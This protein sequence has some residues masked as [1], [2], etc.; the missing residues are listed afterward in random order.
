MSQAGHI[1]C[2]MKERAKP[3]DE[4]VL[5]LGAEPNDH[6]SRYL[7]ARKAEAIYLCG[8]MTAFMES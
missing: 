1:R 7:I 6:P 4:A 5:P 2:T 8:S 3:L